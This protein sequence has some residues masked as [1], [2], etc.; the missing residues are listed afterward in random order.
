MI[1]NDKLRKEITD[2]ILKGLGCGPA[3]NRLMIEAIEMAID[4]TEEMRTQKI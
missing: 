2:G 3:P 1:I 4:R